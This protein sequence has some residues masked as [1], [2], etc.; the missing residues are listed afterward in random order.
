MRRILALA[1]P[2]LLGL[3]VAAGAQEVTT[4]SLADV[5]ASIMQAVDPDAMGVTLDDEVGHDGGVWSLS[6]ADGDGLLVDVDVNDDGSIAMIRRQVAAGDVPA[7]V[8]R[9]L[10]A[11]MPGFEPLF[12]SRTTDAE[13]VRYGFQ[14]I[15]DGAQVS[16]TIAEDGSGFARRA[17]GG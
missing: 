5:P 7:A 3:S 17:I 14:G 9:T 10:E 8:R 1:L 11:R 15:L 16:A 2:A 13:G 6:G 12:I 4:F